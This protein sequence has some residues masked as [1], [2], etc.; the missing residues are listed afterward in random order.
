MVWHGHISNF[1]TKF[2][3]RFLC[4]IDVENVLILMYDDYVFQ[5]NQKIYCSIFYYINLLSCRV[6]ETERVYHVIRW[7][8]ISSDMLDLKNIYII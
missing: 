3:Q 1:P 8:V 4:I 2:N 6:D 7:E 5:L